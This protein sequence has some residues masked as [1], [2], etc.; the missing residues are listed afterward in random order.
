MHKFDVECRGFE[1][2]DWDYRLLCELDTSNTR[3]V[4]LRKKGEES[5]N[6]GT[7]IKQSNVGL[8]WFL[9]AFAKFRKTT[10][11]CVTSVCPPVRPRGTIRLPLDELS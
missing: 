8:N 1:D 10:V 2:G 9:G 11:S 6:S 5:L 7:Y 4:K 3:R